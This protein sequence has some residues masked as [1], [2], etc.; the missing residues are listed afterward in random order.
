MLRNE[1][2]LEVENIGGVTGLR[3]IKL[4][5]PLS[6]IEAPNA[7]G[8]TSIIRALQLLCKNDLVLEDVLNE[9]SATGKVVLRDGEE[10]YFVNLLRTQSGVSI[11]GRLLS[12]DYNAFRLAFCIPDAELVQIITANPFDP[13]R[14]KRWFRDISDARHYETA[15][16]ILNTLIQEKTNEMERLRRSMVD[17]SEIKQVISLN[18]RILEKTEKELEAANKRLKEL[19]YTELVD[20]R[21]EVDWEINRL[22]E[23]ILPLKIERD[24]KRSQLNDLKRRME[25]LKSSMT[26]AYEE[27]EHLTKDL[28]SKEM[29]K[30]AIEQR[31]EA[32]KIR[33]YDERE[34]IIPKIGYLRRRLESRSKTLKEIRGNEEWAPCIK[35]FEKDIEMCS[36]ELK[37]LEEEKKRLDE[38]YD[39]Y[40][41]FFEEMRRL[42]ETIQFV[43]RNIAS[44]NSQI[45]AIERREIPRVER[46]I[47][48]IS[49][50]ISKLQ[51][52]LE[53]KQKEL[54]SLDKRIS[55]LRDVSEELKE[56][57][58]Q[59][60]KE[61]WEARNT[62]SMKKE[63]LE[64]ALRAEEEYSGVVRV[65]D[66]LRD[67][68]SYMQERY[69]YIINGARIELNENLKKVFD[70]MQY[71]NFSKI[72][73]NSDYELE[74]T[75]REG[76]PT[77]L[78]RLSSSERLTISMI[79]MFVAKQAYAPEFPMFVVDEIMGSYDIT[80]FHRI[81]NYI[82]GKVP[83]LIVTSLSPLTDK[84]GAEAIT[85]KH[86][87]K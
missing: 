10:E 17:T 47:D 42:K 30:T 27:L 45:N 54:R 70:L 23:E 48:D 26:D 63:E 1:L 83:Y 59:L 38:E 12:E 4:K 77:K 67:F 5:A 51:V 84:I 56:R 46:E 31:R 65:V 58:S 78:S 64:R 37:D 24:R 87:L 29:Q 61:R 50:K 75:R 8:K 40:N 74:I 22:N 60:N 76:Y 41:A 44:Y 57:I 86:S 15:M 3:S 32:I 2:T 36:K 35:L 82:K 55:E 73:I 52:D 80:R 43:R 11:S 81:L 25:K 21:N 79:I 13:D 18:E 14:L 39:Q 7:S 6:I 85:V 19:G 72:L 68:L 34:G 20:E 69:E 16:V 49:S 53:E 66:R 71:T 28:K 33:L 62:I 9:Y